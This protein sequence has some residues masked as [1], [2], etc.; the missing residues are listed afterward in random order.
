MKVSLLAGFFLL[1]LPG[2]ALA[3]RLEVGEGESGKDLVLGRGD[4]LTVSLP[5]NPTTGYSWSVACT[6]AGVLKQVGESRFE[7]S[8]HCQGMVGVGGRQL[9]KFRAVS[10]GQTRLTFSYSRPWEHDVAPARLIQW[11]ITI[12][13]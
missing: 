10:P 8:G 11:P 6:P 2:I 3:N 4:V 7:T 12:R 5:A 1:L 9:W 13:R